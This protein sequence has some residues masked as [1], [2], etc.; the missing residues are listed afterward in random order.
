MD[1]KKKLRLVIPLHLQKKLGK[2]QLL[3]NRVLGKIRWLCNH[4][5]RA[6]HQERFKANPKLRT[7]RAGS[8]RVLYRIDGSRLQVEWL[9]DRR[10]IYRKAKH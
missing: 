8:Y 1:P 7:A 3:A 9:G 2:N 4:P 10:E 5:Q 6:Y